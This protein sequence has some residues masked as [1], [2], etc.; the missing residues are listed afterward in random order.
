MHSLIGVF[1][2]SEKEE[3]LDQNTTVFP[4]KIIF[5]MNKV[6]VYYCRNRDERSKWLVYLKS[7]VGYATIDDYYDIQGDLGKGKFG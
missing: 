2:K 5:P 7:A 6:R 1:V 4:F 3:Q